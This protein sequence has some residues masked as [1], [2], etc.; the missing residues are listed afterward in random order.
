MHSNTLTVSSRQKYIPTV[1]TSNEEWKIS[2]PRMREKNFLIIILVS[3]GVGKM[4]YLLAMI[5]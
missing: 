4:L 2:E 3:V 5:A 1:V